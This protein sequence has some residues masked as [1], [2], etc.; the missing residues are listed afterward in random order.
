M[1]ALSLNASLAIKAIR[2]EGLEG[3]FQKALD[4]SDTFQNS[5]VAS[6]FVNL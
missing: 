1:P 4:L 6:E 5:S 3:N 2:G